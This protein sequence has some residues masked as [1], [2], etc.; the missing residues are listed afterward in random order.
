MEI[1]Y[2]LGGGTLGEVAKEM[3]SPPTRP[4]LR[5]IAKSLEEKGYLVQ[6]GKDGREYV[7]QPTRQP[8][9]EGQAA[10]G[11]VLTTF[12]GGSIRDGLAAY[13]SDPSVELS[14]KEL[15]QIEA[16]VREARRRAGD[17]ES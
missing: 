12:F 3:E 8:K 5:S 7:Y 9:R 15:K 2:A 14:E 13:F 1:V 16:L 4:A 10:W 17:K 11:K 6:S